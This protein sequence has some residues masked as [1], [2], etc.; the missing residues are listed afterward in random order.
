VALCRLINTSRLKNRVP[1]Y[2]GQTA[3]RR[4]VENGK[5]SRPSTGCLPGSL[6]PGCVANPGCEWINAA[7][8]GEGSQFAG[9]SCFVFTPL[10]QP[11]CPPN[12]PQCAQ[13]PCSYVLPNPCGGGGGGGGNG[14]VPTAP[15]PTVPQS[16]KQKVCAALIMY[17]KQD[18]LNAGV[19]RGAA[20]AITKSS[21][22]LNPFADGAVVVLL[23]TSAVYTFAGLAEAGASVAA[24]CP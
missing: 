16:T 20:A 17:A 18:L 14:P 6:L 9:N 5:V 4:S 21:W 1:L 19:D 15:S 23:S 10:P 13:S 3:S 24:K 11:N 7:G 2:K 8:S 22:G 12:I